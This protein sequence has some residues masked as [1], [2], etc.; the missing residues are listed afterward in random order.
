MKKN[1]V[2]ILILL[3]LAGNL[4]FIQN[5]AFNK[6]NSNDDPKS[7]IEFKENLVENTPLSQDYTTNSSGEEVTEIDFLTKVGLGIRSYRN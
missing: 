6:I 2:I 5:K 3:I 4:I 7:I 1:R